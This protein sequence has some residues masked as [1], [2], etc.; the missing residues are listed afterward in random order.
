[1]NIETV[2][3]SST[4]G[5]ESSSENDRSCREAEAMASTQVVHSNYVPAQLHRQLQFLDYNVDGHLVLGSC[6]L[7]GRLWTGSLWYYRDPN[8]APS[9]QKALTG[10]DCDSG[11]VD[12]KFIGD[13][14][15]NML[16]AC[17]DG[18]LHHI[19]LSFSD[20]GEEESFFLFGDE[21]GK[22]RA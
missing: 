4:K 13:R 20:E 6:D 15:K 3:D 2:A 7:T 18:S 5:L 22:P 1:M 9:V 19:S 10:V 12:G 11:C 8:D 21:S 17:D 16:V 14:T